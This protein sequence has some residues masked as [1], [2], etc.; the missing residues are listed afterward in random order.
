MSGE[1]IQG[2]EISA[3]CRPRWQEVFEIWVAK[4]RGARQRDYR[5]IWV[6]FADF[7]GQKP[8]EVK[9]EDVLRWRKWLE[10]NDFATSTVRTYL[11]ILASFY[12]FAAECGMEKRN[13]VGKYILPKARPYSSGR[14]LSEEEEAALLGAIDRET[15]WGLRDYA[16]ILFLLRSGRRAGE[17]LGLRWGDFEVR[18]EGVWYHWRK[19]GGNDPKDMHRSKLKWEVWAGITSYLEA[20]GRLEGMKE[21][22]ILFTPLTDMAG[23]IERLHGLD[24]RYQAL[25]AGSIGRLIQMYAR[26]AGLAAD[27]ISPKA[28]RYTAAVRK[29]NSGCDL[30]TLREFMGFTNV[31]PARVLVKKLMALKATEDN[32]G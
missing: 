4:Q 2:D 9:P 12:D 15:A 7:Y 25:A 10:D 21:E 16:L 32:P 3:I 6:N 20:C 14:Y 26:W 30:D 22:D 23:R 5:R 18:K 28:L 8:E 13:P 24:W 31:D 17:I 29:W 11:A 1:L 19:P 27:E